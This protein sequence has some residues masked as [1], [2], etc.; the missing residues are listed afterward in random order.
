MTQMRQ[1]DGER[2]K[3]PALATLNKIFARGLDR[4]RGN[5]NHDRMVEPRDIRERASQLRR[6]ASVKTEGGQAADRQLIAFAHKLERLAD[7]LEHRDRI[8]QQRRQA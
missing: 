4:A 6:A 8:T 2:A 1:F 3:A 5:R 7:D